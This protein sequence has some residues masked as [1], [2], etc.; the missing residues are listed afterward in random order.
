VV[1]ITGSEPSFST[2]EVLIQRSTHPLEIT[3][4]HH[5]ITQQVPVDKCASSL[6]TLKT[7]KPEYTKSDHEVSQRKALRIVTVATT[8][9]ETI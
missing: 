9:L 8:Q 5:K 1:S 2:T 4:S 3:E 7:L 6:F